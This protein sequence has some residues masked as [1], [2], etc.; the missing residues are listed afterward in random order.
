MLASRKN[1]PGSRK[2][3]NE[4]RALAL[5]PVAIAVLFAAVALP[6]AAVPA[7]APLPVADMAKVDAVLSADAARVRALG[8]TPLPSSARAVGSA[9]RA[10]FAAQA[11]GLPDE[12]VAILHEKI[13]AALRFEETADGIDA[14]VAL[15][16]VYVEEFVARLAEA[17]SR[18]V[19]RTTELDELAGPIV[20]RLSEAGLGDGT[21]LRLSKVEAKVLYRQ[22]FVG[23]LGMQGRPEL[24]PS[25]DE[26]R[27]RYAILLGRGRPGPRD[28]RQLEALPAV[29]LVPSGGVENE[30]QRCERF[31][32][33]A[34]RLLAAWRLNKVRELGAI[35]P[36]YPTLYAMGILAYQHGD[37]NQSVGAMREWLEEHP[38]GPYAL[39]AENFLR[40]GLAATA[41]QI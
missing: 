33:A 29:A 15:R 32:A 39:R 1:H 22:M 37:Y 21:R 4:G 23:A 8:S 40:A 27:V 14:L 13:E 34:T 11:A 20:A 5:I 28:Q 2:K 31:S 7:E 36:S 30:D 24:A 9:V 35:D 17:A 41:K 10:F 38:R 3:T 16:A 6:R 25:L 26:E 18:N 12:Q 19:A